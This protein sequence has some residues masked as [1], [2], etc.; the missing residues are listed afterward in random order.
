[1]FIVEAVNYT[2]KSGFSHIKCNFSF[3]NK[4]F[5][6]QFSVSQFTWQIWQ[7]KN[8]IETNKPNIIMKKALM[9]CLSPKK[10]L[11]PRLELTA[12]DVV[13]HIVDQ[14]RVWYH[15]AIQAPQKLTLVKNYKF[16]SLLFKLW[17][18]LFY[19]LRWTRKSW[20]PRNKRNYLQTGPQES[21]W[22]GSKQNYNVTK[23]TYTTEYSL[24]LVKSSL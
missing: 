5:Y 19:Q 11:S 2:S 24:C 13:H 4:F 16:V 23:P 15:S 17:F 1:M 22:T 10:R 6:F 14:S 7:T 18:M 8:S 3:S 12:Q 21:V 20:R 9:L